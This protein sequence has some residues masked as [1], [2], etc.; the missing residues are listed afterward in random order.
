MK[1]IMK[2]LIKFILSFLFCF[3]LNVYAQ[4]T[5]NTKELPYQ[6]IKWIQPPSI[7]IS[8]ND[9]QGY[10]RNVVIAAETNIGGNITAVKLLQSSGIKSLDLKLII[11]VENARF[12][13]Y[14]ENGVFYP[15]RFVQPFHLEA[16]REPEFE[17]YPEI[18]VNDEDLYGQN[19]SV[20]I[21]TEADVNGTLTRAEIQKSSGL[22]K[23]D[24]FVLD[25]F[26]EHAK[27]FPLNVNG[28][29]YPIRKTVAYNFPSSIT[30]SEAERYKKEYQL[31]IF[32][33]WDVPP[34][35]AGTSAR[36]RILLTDKG[37][38]N[39]IIFLNEVS[40]EFKLSIERAIKK[41]IPF[42]LPENTDIRKIARNLS[43][44]FKAT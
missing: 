1:L 23:L 10:D 33:A 35:S 38:I 9:L 34:N 17:V 27:F 28:K 4:N 43:I 36:V 25:E 40:K 16:S 42:T 41:S 39:Q 15:V 14:Q 20:S 8:N 19:R 5:T 32:K 7:M 44:S 18:K 13:P 31:K 24:N 22:I 2:I 30:S 37:E 21:F 29:P 11:A 6:K 12:S 26:R 3:A